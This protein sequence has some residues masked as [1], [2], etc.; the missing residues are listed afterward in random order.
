[1]KKLNLRSMV[2]LALCC[3]LGLFA[4]KIIGPFANV[5]TD[6]LHIPGGIGTSFSLMF[7]VVSVALVP[8]FG[9]GTVF[10]AVQSVLA[11]FFGMVGSMGALA[12]IGYIT[13]G[14]AVD[15]LFLL[16][17]RAGTHLCDKMVAGNALAAVCASL[18]ANLIVFRLRGVVLMLYLCVAASTG[19]LCGYLGYLIVKRVAPVLRFNLEKEKIK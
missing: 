9:C 11:F 7:L 14:L 16:T 18:T 6:F 17:R 5:I 3:D 15:L 12:P 1:M 8:K 10:G 2:F 4:K 19:V 13:P